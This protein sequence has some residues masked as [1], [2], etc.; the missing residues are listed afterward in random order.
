MLHRRSI[1]RTI[2]RLRS[3]RRLG[4]LAIAAVGVAF[5]AVPAVVRAPG[6]L[7][8][9]CSTWI[10]LAGALELLSICG[11]VVVFKLVFAP[12][13]SWR[14]SVAAGLRAIGATTIVPAGGLVGPAIGARTAS[15]RQPSPTAT[16]R[17]AIAFAMVTNV[18]EAIAVVAIGLSLWLGWLGG[19]GGAALTLL[20]AGAA[21][22][23]L[24][25]AW[26]VSRW[27]PR[28]NERPRARSSSRLAPRLAAAAQTVPA[29]L[30][31]GWQLL[32]ARDW[33]LVGAVGYWAFDN[34]TLWA[35]F[36]AYG[37]APPL[38]VVAMGYLIGSLTTALPLPAGLGAVEGGLI[39]A[40]VLYG[41][42]P[43]SAAAAVFLYRGISL[44][45][46][47]GLSA[48]GWAAL[49]RPEIRLFG[50]RA[51]RRQPA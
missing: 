18:P 28:A 37:H 33:K 27:L 49:V 4:W 30:R 14:E 12:Q 43:A 40:L 25:A 36:R 7:T 47:V 42:R 46:P 51:R 15:S 20:P 19:P 24:A 21:A 44:L 38:R 6:R 16:A 34:A 17:S 13:R 32:G 48:F 50:A 45:L 9:G 41:T 29:G 1:Q 23:V 26:L 31:E 22:A 3:N 8:A 2:V 5:L 10:V 35:A 11:F 39:G